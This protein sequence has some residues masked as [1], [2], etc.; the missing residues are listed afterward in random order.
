MSS[1]LELTQCLP[2]V[3][4]LFPGQ[5]RSFANDALL[6]VPLCGGRWPCTL[7]F[8]HSFESS[9][10]FLYTF[11]SESLINFPNVGTFVW[12]LFLL[13]ICFLKERCF[14]FLIRTKQYCFWVFKCLEAV[15]SKSTFNLADLASIYLQKLSSHTLLTYFS[16]PYPLIAYP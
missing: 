5:A 16:C 1:F 14:F 3:A 2:F 13:V 4:H 6:K 7:V 12:L 9:G 8:P 10:T 15:L 11:W